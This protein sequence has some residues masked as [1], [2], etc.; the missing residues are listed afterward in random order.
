MY[1]IAACFCRFL[2]GAGDQQVQTTVYSVIATTF[3]SKRERYL[4]FAGSA[5]GVGQ[6]LGPVLGGL[7]NSILGYMSNY[8]IFCGL[9]FIQAIANF[10]LIPSYLN[11]KP[12]IS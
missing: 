10:F 11:N 8:L 9:L 3:I 4:G 6:L 7:L 2:S 12:E 5:C 1:F